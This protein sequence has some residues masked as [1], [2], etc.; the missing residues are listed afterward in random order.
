MIYVNEP[1]YRGV[2]GSKRRCTHMP[3]MYWTEKARILLSFSE[4][5]LKPTKDVPIVF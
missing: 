5:C 2:E 1:S 3:Y 4:N